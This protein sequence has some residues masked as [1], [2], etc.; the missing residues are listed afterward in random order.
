[1]WGNLKSVLEGGRFSI[2]DT[3]SLMADLCSVGYRY[4]SAG[5][6]VLE[7]KEDLRKRGMPSPD[8]GDAVALCFTEPGGV[9]YQRVRQYYREPDCEWV[10]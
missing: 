5:R 6:L 1:M 10:V 3:D 9:V 4:D 8:E 2:P 7:S